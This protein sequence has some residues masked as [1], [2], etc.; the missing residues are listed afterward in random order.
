MTAEAEFRDAVAAGEFVRAQALWPHLALE[1]EQLRE[2][3]EWTRRTVA[4]AR[5][6]ALDEIRRREGC[7]LYAVRPEAEAHTIQIRG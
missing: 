4:A 3:L 7:G 1:A 6:H 5:A 2:L